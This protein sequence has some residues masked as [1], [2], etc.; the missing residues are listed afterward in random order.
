MATY[1][2]MVLDE[3]GSMGSIKNDTI[4]GFNEYL[5]NIQEVLTPRKNVL[6]SLLTFNSGKMRWV[7]DDVALED[8]EMLDE[9]SYC[10]NN[11]TPLYDAVGNALARIDE[12]CA[13]DDD[14]I[15]LSIITDGEENS[16]IEYT[17]EAVKKSIE[18]V[19][20]KWSITFLGANID[21]WDA[22][23]RLG[24]FSGSTIA[25]DSTADGINR[26][27][28]GLAH[29]HTQYLV[30]EASVEN[31]FAGAKSIDEYADTIMTEGTGE[32][33]KGI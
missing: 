24:T 2:V 15:V 8:V 7:Y 5:K 27:M 1:I 3:S 32:E 30:G 20:D 13:E 21:V 17:A 26:T 22:G 4:G 11:A 25:Y 16:S 33:E 19:R 10:P 12:Y 23:A 28:G 6:F 18:N 9:R 31:M 29:A 14:K